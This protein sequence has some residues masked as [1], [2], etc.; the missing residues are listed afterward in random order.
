MTG[1]VQDYMILNACTN[2]CSHP[3]IKK[4]K[5]ITFANTHISRYAPGLYAMGQSPFGTCSLPR[6]SDRIRS[7]RNKAA[8]EL[9]AVEQN[10]FAHVKF[11]MEDVPTKSYLTV[12][13]K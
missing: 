11:Q 1:E 2:L 9:V 12:L 10:K 13:Y 8:S 3:I 7:Y 5:K 4:K 6:Q